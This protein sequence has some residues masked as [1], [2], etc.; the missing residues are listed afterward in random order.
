MHRPELR[1]RSCVCLFIS[2]I[3]ATIVQA[4]ILDAL[5]QGQDLGQVP[6]SAAPRIRQLLS[7]IE[8]D[9]IIIRKTT[10]G[11]GR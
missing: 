3:V 8:T 5:R 6:I 9:I 11:N 1:F 7:Q 2:V 10:V 4:A